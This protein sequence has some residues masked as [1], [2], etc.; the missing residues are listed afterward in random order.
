MKRTLSSLAV[1]SLSALL[2]ACGADN[3]G[4]G[5]ITP[6]LQD[7]G[8]PAVDAGTDGSGD[9]DEDAG[10]T[11]DVTGDDTSATPEAGLFTRS[12][13]HD[14]LERTYLLYVPASFDASGSAPLM[15]N[16]HGFSGTAQGQ[17]AYADMRPLADAEGFLLA[18]PQGSL[19]D[20]GETHWNPVLEQE[21]NKSDA[22]DFGFTEKMLDA[23]AAD[24]PFDAARVY[25]TGY[26]N[27]ADFSYG[28]AC[29]LSDRVAAI[30]P[31]SGSMSTPMLGDCAANHPTSVLIFNGTADFVRPYE[32]YPGYLLSVDEAT[33]FWAEHNAS[34][35][36]PVTDGP[37][38]GALTVE[39]ER[40]LDGDGGA[41]VTLYRV[42][43]GGHEWF[44][45]DEDGAD[46]N[47]L[48]W[49]F[50]SRFDREGAR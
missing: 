31:V 26:S 20:T 27:G 16:F 19:L 29:Y 47:A 46:M 7:T 18:Y 37:D 45:M 13:Q 34:T 1:A 32:G 17:L 5:V 49:G 3:T 35:A 23:I 48:V 8:N 22:D 21:D 38:V 28:L 15:L 6:G 44:D 42:V 14:D 50:V 10:P 2:A 11:E 25:A 4:A 41:E 40:Y 30:A 39:R 9:S 24:Y 36:E 12:V 43:N 33:A